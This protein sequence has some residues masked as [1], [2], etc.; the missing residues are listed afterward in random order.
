MSVLWDLP[1]SGILGLNRVV[2]N[3]SI[4]TAVVGRRGTS[5][6]CVNDHAHLL[7]PEAAL[8]SYR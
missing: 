7:D 8:L 5:L 2:V 1:R 3:G 6:L 4:T